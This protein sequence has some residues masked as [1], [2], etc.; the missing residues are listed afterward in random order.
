MSVYYTKC[1]MKKGGGRGAS[2]EV[3]WG[4]GLKIKWKSVLVCANVSQDSRTFN[5]TKGRATIL[6]GVMAGA[7]CGGCGGGE[8]GEGV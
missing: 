3:G 1:A 4:G 5:S 6:G 2:G 8:Q 7:G